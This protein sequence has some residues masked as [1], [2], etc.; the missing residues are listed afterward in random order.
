MNDSKYLIDINDKKNWLKINMDYNPDGSLNEEQRIIVW[1]E[2]I[3]QRF[4]FTDSIFYGKNGYHEHTFG[5]EIFFMVEGSMDFTTHGK[6]CTVHSGDILFVP[7]YTSH[8]MEFLEPTRWRATFH[9]MNMCEILNDWNRI[10]KYCD[11]KLDDPV[12]EANY[13]AN[14]QNVLRELPV[15]KRVDK[16][17]VPEVRTIDKWKNRYDFEGI[18]MKQVADRS[19]NNGISEMWRLEMQDKF[20]VNYEPVVP[21]TDFFYITEGEVD[22]EVGG[23]KFTAYHDCLVKI[24]SYIPRKFRSKGTSVMY[25]IGGITHWL[26]VIEDWMSLKQ[27]SAEKYNNK[28]YVKEV[29]HRHSCYVSGFG[30]D[31]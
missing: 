17:E 6:V 2:G 5:W 21:Q 23:E 8:S 24:P 22:F 16:S 14:P 27:F 9:D 15:A 12:L 19:E 1:P 25:D 4:D 20:T 7:P 29:L 28:E 11:S 31:I 18:V 13:L 3:H 10:Q 30:I 26:D